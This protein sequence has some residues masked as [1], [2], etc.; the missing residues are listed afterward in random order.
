MTTVDVEVVERLLK[1]E[2]EDP[3]VVL[4][5][6]QPQVIAAHEQ[7]TEEYRGALFVASRRSLLDQLGDPRD[8][9]PE[10]ERI[11]AILSDMADRLGA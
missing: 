3:V 11:A 7:D 4:L 1:S 9:P 5:Q 8:S 10:L 2:V 6:G